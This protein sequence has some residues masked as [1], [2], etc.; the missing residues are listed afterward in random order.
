MSFHAQ[1]TLLSLLQ[2]PGPAKM[3]VTT[4]SSIPSAEKVPTT[5]STLWQEEMRVKD[6]PDGSNLSPAQSPS[7]SQPPATS[8]L[9]E[10]GLEGK[11]GMQGPSWPKCLPPNVPPQ[12]METGL[13]P[14]R[15]ALVFCVH[16]LWA[17]PGL[18]SG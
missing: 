11:D 5:K 17:A 10:P 1:Q 7:Q 4:S 3:A 2:E 12:N 18:V 14:F 15:G 16:Q 8:T 13:Y 9:R 6:Q